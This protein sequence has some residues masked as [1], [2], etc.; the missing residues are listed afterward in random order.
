MLLQ[1]ESV[2][3]HKGAVCFLQDEEDSTRCVVEAYE[4]GSWRVRLLGAAEERRVPESALRFSYSLLPAALDLNECYVQLAIEDAQGNCGRG[5]K[6]CEAIPMG[7][8]LFAEP[9]FIVTYKTNR[10]FVDHHAQRWTAYP[11][12]AAN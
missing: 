9:P 4:H 6:V 2:Q 10:A 1:G 11:A 3:L 7:T 8:Q 5:L 12:L